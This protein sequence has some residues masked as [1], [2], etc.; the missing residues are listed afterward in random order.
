VTP[1]VAVVGLGTMGK[2]HVRTLS[3][4]GDVD[5]V[6]VCDAREAAVEAAV[7]ERRIAGYRDYLEMLERERLDAVIVAVPTGQ[8]LK[9]ASSALSHGVDVL[10]EKP[11]AATAEEGRALIDMAKRAGRTLAVGH[12]ERFNPA[13]VE[14]E[15]RVSHGELGRVFQVHASR[16]G[17][18]PARVRDVGVVVDLATHD[19]DVVS[20]IVKSSIERLYAETEQRI[21]TEHEDLL[22]ALIKFQNDVVAVLQVNW[23][24]PTKIRRLSV[25]G[26]KGLFVA[27]YITQELS[28]FR[29]TDFEGGPGRPPSLSGVSEGE[30]ER[31]PVNETEPLKVE[32]RSFFDSIAHGRP[33]EVDG[34]AGL[35]AL[36]LALALVASASQHRVISGE[37][38]N[39]PRSPKPARR[40][41]R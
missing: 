8:H 29:N 33:A 39:I 28:Y 1:R 38:L 17:P 5:L 31:L 14:L 16:Q 2:N 37:E 24:T 6:A 3:E 12:V 35:R 34:E 4:L 23:L 19:L 27:D 26:E 15:R 20:H 22:N 13:V 10:V 18:F 25:L 40:A 9:V 36:Q 30:M 32:L 21:H 41:R 11:I 7:G